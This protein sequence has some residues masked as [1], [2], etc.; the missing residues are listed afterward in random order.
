[1][2]SEARSL[3]CQ[4]LN[5]IKR[6]ED[7]SKVRENEAPFEDQVEAK[8]NAW[9][10]LSLQVL[11]LLTGQRVT[12]EGLKREMNI[13]QRVRNDNCCEH[14]NLNGPDIRKRR[15]QTINRRAS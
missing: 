3:C 10:L 7:N 9:L 2:P 8:D 6:D 1:M 12:M 14:V 4:T 11:S 15:P 5:A 13:A